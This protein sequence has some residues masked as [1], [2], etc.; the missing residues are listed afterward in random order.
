M[1]SEVLLNIGHGVC[2]INRHIVQS[3]AITHSSHQPVVNYPEAVIDNGVERAKLKGPIS[4]SQ[5]RQKSEER[6]IPLVSTYNPSNTNMIP[7]FRSK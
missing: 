7:F 6:G 4:G 2:L 1:W 3:H 5:D